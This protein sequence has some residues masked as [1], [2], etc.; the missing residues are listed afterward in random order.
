[1]V[2]VETFEPSCQPQLSPSPAIGFDS[3]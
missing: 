3:S 1:M 2:I